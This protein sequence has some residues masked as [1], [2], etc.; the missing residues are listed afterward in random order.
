MLAILLGAAAARADG[1]EPIRIQF[2]APVGCPDSAAFTDQVRARTAKAR[3][4]APGERARTFSVS[5]TQEPRISKGQLTIED[6]Q[7]E[8]AV[9]EVS[10]QTCTEVVAALALITALAI[11]PDASTS[12]QAPASPAPLPA[13]PPAPPRSASPPMT[14][15]GFLPAPPPLPA[16][17]SRPRALTIDDAIWPPLAMPLPIWIPPAEA[18]VDTSRWRAAVGAHLLALGAVAPDLVLG[19]AVFIDV[20]R[21]GAGVLSPTFRLSVLRAASDSIQNEAGVASLGFT[22]GRLEGC[23][24]RL[25]IEPSFGVSP[26]ALIDAGALRGTGTAGEA[27]AAETRPWVAAGIG[28]RL[29]WDVLDFLLIEA[30]GGLVIPIVRDTFFFEPDVIIHEVPAVGGYLAAG[31]AIRF[32]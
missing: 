24:V 2:Q 16:P 3:P 18:E 26:C 29:Q 30:E 23:P 17:S 8:S 13:P 22:A 19:T 28:G 4:A 10:G 20:S 5:V 32:P 12:P 6:K 7:G 15:T 21:T 31:A 14:G 25:A 9:R 1:V 11:D 27:S